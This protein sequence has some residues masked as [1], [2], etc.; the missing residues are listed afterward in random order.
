MT[1]CSMLHNAEVMTLSVTNKFKSSVV[2]GTQFAFI[3]YKLSSSRIISISLGASMFQFL[4]LLFDNMKIY[5][6]HVTFLLK[7]AVEALSSTYS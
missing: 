6:S 7:S 4:L 2:D 3:L 5:V 1:R